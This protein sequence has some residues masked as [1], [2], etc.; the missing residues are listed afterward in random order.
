MDGEN[1]GKSYEQMDDLEYTHVHPIFGNTHFK[2]K[3]NI[4][5]GHP[6]LTRES[7]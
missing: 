5:N 1:S 3:F 7:F 4:G 2:W 6:K